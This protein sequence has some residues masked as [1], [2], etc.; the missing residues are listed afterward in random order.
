MNPKKSGQLLFLL[1]ISPIF[2]I[3]L[4]VFLVIANTP[5]EEKARNKATFEQQKILAQQ[6]WQQQKEQEEKNRLAIEGS[7]IQPNEKSPIYDNQK[8]RLMKIDYRYFLVPKEYGGDKSFSFYWPSSLQKEYSTAIYHNQI[9]IQKR[10]KATIYV[11]MIS[12]HSYRY[13]KALNN[14]NQKKFCMFPAKSFLWNDIIISLDFDQINLRDWPAICQETLRILN[15]V[16]EV[17]P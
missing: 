1:M 16:K 12:K 6:M 17:K 7:I 11:M 13:H 14:H 10:N 5:P 15:L 9:D 2:I 4:I 8:Y 3:G